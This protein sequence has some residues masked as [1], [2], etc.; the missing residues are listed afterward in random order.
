M[1]SMRR[2]EADARRYAA[3]FD[4]EEFQCRSPKVLPRKKPW[5]LL[6]GNQGGKAFW[7]M[8]LN[9][10]FKDGSEV[11]VEGSWT[12][13][14][15]SA[16]CMTGEVEMAVCHVW[17]TSCAWMRRSCIGSWRRIPSRIREMES[18][19]SWAEV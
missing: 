1:G 2:H 18:A 8:G 5:F 17:L 10:S 19:L 14:K 13:E 7:S 3:V 12:G 11:E 9:S 6:R 15:K 16:C 4:G